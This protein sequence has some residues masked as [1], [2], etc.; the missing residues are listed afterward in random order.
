MSQELITE[1]TGYR[2]TKEMVE[3]LMLAGEQLYEYRHEQLDNL[4]EEYDEN[5]DPAVVYEKD[6]VELSEAIEKRY[7]RY[8]EQKEVIS[9]KE[10]D[11]MEIEQEEKQH[12]KALQRKSENAQE[13][14]PGKEKKE[15][16]E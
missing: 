15:T 2:T 6:P 7:V 9:E 1:Q 12:E 8:R 14:S 16:L 5:Q 4:D 13:A 3:A 10:K 11:K